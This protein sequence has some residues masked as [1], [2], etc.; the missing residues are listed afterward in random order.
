MITK[1]HKCE[2]GCLFHTGEVRKV[3]VTNHDRD[4][5]CF[6]YCHDAVYED[7]SNGFAVEFVED[8]DNSR[9]DK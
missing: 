1:E 4:W 2:G 8:D 9:G 5:G 7:I 3:R 6:Y